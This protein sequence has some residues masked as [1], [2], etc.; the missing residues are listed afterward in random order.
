M[1]NFF[2]IVFNKDRHN[3]N[4]YNKLQTDNLTAGKSSGLLTL[5]K[6]N[7]YYKHITG[8]SPIATQFIIFQQADC[9]D[10]KNAS[11]SK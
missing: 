4:L 8:F 7:N 2:T 10:A 9:A 1:I 6:M 5:S 3:S 11:L